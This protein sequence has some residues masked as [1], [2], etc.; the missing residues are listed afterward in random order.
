MVCSRFYVLAQQTGGETSAA[1]SSAFLAW[2]LAGGLLATVVGL[3]VW[4]VLSS[5]NFNSLFVPPWKP[6]SR[7]PVNSNLT[8]A[9]VV[10]WGVFLTV[11]LTVFWHFDY[12]H[13]WTIPGI[14]D[15]VTLAWQFWSLLVTILVAFGLARV[16]AGAILA[17][18]ENTSVRRQFELLCP[19]EPSAEAVASS[20]RLVHENPDAAAAANGEEVVDPSETATAAGPEAGESFADTFAR[21]LGILIYLMILLPVLM[22]ASEIW[23]WTVTGS[24][25]GQIWNWLLPFTALTAIITIGWFALTAAAVAIAPPE[26][27]RAVMIATTLMALIL[28]AASYSTSFA[29]VLA[30]VVLGLAWFT[31]AELPDL[32]AGQLLRLQKKVAIRTI[33]GSARL[34]EIGPLVSELAGENRELQVRNRHLLQTYISGGILDENRVLPQPS[35]ALPDSPFQESVPETSR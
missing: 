26:Q 34:K 5:M 1:F 23:G 22:I 27:R 6:L 31:R 18:F 15:A 2:G 14:D 13:E 17:I 30:V 12:Q 24:T 33:S 20:S 4:Y 3:L 35:P 29:I 7:R 28:L 21:L 32:I 16:V 8:P 25:V 19:N 11:L 10:S 9:A